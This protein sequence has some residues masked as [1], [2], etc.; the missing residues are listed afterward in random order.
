MYSHRH[1]LDLAVFYLIMSYITFL[2][3]ETKSGWNISSKY[4]LYAATALTFIFCGLLIG[5]TT[6]LGYIIFSV[7]ILVICLPFIR[8]LLKKWLTIRKFLN[9]RRNR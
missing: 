7:I 4:I 8:I 3:K 1:L 2:L 5:F 9:K 6:L